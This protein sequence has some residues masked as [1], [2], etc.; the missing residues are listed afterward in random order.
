[1]IGFLVFIVSYIIGIIGWSIVVFI[2]NYIDTYDELREELC[3][4]P[5]FIPFINIL[6]V[7]G[8]GIV[9]ISV[10]I[11][12]YIYKYCGIEKLWNKIKDKKLPFRE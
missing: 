9:A 3:S 10:S 2:G 11:V 1:M 5:A 12:M 6:T 4:T 8:L 7:I